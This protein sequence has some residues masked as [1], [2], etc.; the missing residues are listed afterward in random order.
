[1]KTI[2]KSLL[3]WMGIIPLAIINGIFREAVLNSVINGYAAMI[4]SGVILSLLIIAMTVIFIPK[5]PH[6]DTAT[7]L[8]TGLVWILA[9]ILFETAFGLASGSTF[10]EIL[11]AYDLTT[12]NLWLIVV[13]VTGVSPWLAAKLRK[14][15]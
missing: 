13:L 3:I 7:Y 9:T 12:G 5:L 2:Y 10:A 4:V 11:G 1:M 14:I 15:I 8:K 6:A